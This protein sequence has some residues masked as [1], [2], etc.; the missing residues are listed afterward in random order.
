MSPE[1]AFLLNWQVY[2]AL[3]LTAY[4]NVAVRIEDGGHTGQ[5]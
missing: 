1:A 5:Q 2:R 3:Q 4:S